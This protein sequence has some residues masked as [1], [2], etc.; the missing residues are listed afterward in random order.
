MRVHVYV[1]VCVRVS[2][3]IPGQTLTKLE[4]LTLTTKPRRLIGAPLQFQ[5]LNGNN[6]NPNPCYY[7]SRNA[8]YNLTLTLTLSVALTYFLPS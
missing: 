6:L 1:C 4:T 5:K 2:V 3:C 8:T 7:L